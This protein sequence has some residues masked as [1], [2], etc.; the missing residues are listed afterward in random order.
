MEA[1][2]DH[3]CSAVRPGRTEEGDRRKGLRLSRLC[4]ARAWALYH[5]SSQL[6][7]RLLIRA[8]L[9]TFRR[10]AYEYASI[11]APQARHI[12]P[13]PKSLLLMPREATADERSSEAVLQSTEDNRGALPV[14]IS[15]S[16]PYSACT[17]KK[18]T[19][20]IG[21]IRNPLGAEFGEYP[22]V[23]CKQCHTVY[24]TRFP[25]TDWY[26]CGEP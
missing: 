25:F 12:S 15:F 4:R 2:S 17:H 18:L 20:S 14:M 23:R 24:F 13:Y 6:L 21:V 26:Y 10:K 11:L 1:A 22:L 8:F 9:L 5:S 16:T 3:A 19:Y 7:A